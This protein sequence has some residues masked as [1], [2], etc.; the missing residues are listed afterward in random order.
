MKTKAQFI[1]DVTYEVV[2]TD[3]GK[4]STERVTLQRAFFNNLEEGDDWEYIYA[5]QDEFEA[6]LKLEQGESM[7]FRPDRGSEAWGLILRIK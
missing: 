5:M 4:V 6:I 7:P 2:M 3:G 1:E